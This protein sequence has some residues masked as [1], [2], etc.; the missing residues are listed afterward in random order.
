M[1]QS[2]MVN[3]MADPA[4]VAELVEILRTRVDASEAAALLLAADGNVELAVS[5][6]F[7]AEEQAP[8]SISLA[9][10]ASNTADEAGPS[11]M[12]L[13]KSPTSPNA[14]QSSAERADPLDKGD[15]LGGAGPNQETAGQRDTSRTKLEEK[16][17][18]LREL[19]GPN[20]GD[21]TLKK[22]LRK[23]KGCVNAAANTHFAQVQGFQK[24]Q[25]MRATQAREKQRG[26]AANYT[27]VVIEAAE[28]TE[29]AEGKHGVKPANLLSLQGLMLKAVTR[30]TCTSDK[31][32]SGRSR[33][34]NLLW[35]HEAAVRNIRQQSCGVVFSDAF[36]V[37]AAR[38]MHCQAPNGSFWVYYPQ[39]IKQGFDRA[40][41]MIRLFYFGSFAKKL[42]IL[43]A[44][45]SWSLINRVATY[46]IGHM[47]GCH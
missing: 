26:F 42:L 31:Q 43:I 46:S 33:A 10:P 12:G 45:E 39:T 5:M 21:A 16:V 2:S 32:V 4:R 44:T 30:N 13:S 47:N 34:S 20:V 8:S 36:E 41:V 40:L 22:K 18:M 23:A 14:L 29:G 6:Y 28:S 19:V 9:L 35:L 37:S 11:N 3:A 38:Y 1:H 7:S 25:E 15:S 24:R 27:D 17:A